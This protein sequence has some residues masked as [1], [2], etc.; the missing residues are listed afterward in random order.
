MPVMPSPMMMMA[1]MP[2]QQKCGSRFGDGLRAEYRQRGARVVHAADPCHRQGQAAKS[3]PFH[4]G[5]R[6]P[7]IQRT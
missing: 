7:A 2:G 6:L 5:F 3:D 4:P 1:T